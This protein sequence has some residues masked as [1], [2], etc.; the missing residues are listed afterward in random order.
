MSRWLH[1]VPLYRRPGPSM[2]PHPGA[3]WIR[4]FRLLPPITKE[5]IRQGFP[6]NFLPAGVRLDDLLERGLVELESTSG[7]TDDA[8]PLL[9]ERGG[10][11]RQEAA[12]LHLNADVRAH[13]T[14]S[15]RRITITS[16]LCNHDISY[17]GTPTAADRVVG[18][19]LFLNLNRHPFLWTTAR[20][21][22]MI[23]EAFDWRPIFLDC[24]PVYGL[25]FARHCRRRGVRLPSLRFVV[26]SYG[27]LSLCHRRLLAS[28]FEIPVYNLYGATETGHLL[29]EDEQGALRPS[30]STAWLEILH[31]D[32][33]G[34]G[35]LVVTTLWNPSMPLIRYSIGDLVSCQSGIGGESYRVHGRAR[36]ALATAAGRRITVAHI[37]AQ[38]SLA[39]GVIHYQLN[40][41]G[42]DRFHLRWIP[43][44]R[45][46]IP[47]TEQ[48]LRRHL[49]P[50]LENPRQLQIESIEAILGE[51]SGKFRLAARRDLPPAGR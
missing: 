42:P 3:D 24:D 39:E 41:L 20:L 51:P 34:I 43:D 48:A 35:D 19:A 40:Q 18:D 29:M 32:S 28:A 22:A 31:P 25:V 14:P 9:L 46:D 23:E 5:D 44:D 6:G 33:D 21:D 7:T 10:W 45:A 50:L 47:S 11:A 26:S 16:P 13:W 2:A 38:V 37:D 12:A 36:D 17:Q 8:I 30:P 27:F 49:S 15:V 4:D 1:E